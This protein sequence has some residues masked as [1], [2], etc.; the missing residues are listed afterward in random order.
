M[1]HV[2]MQCG[3]FVPRP[4]GPGADV[5]SVAAKESIRSSATSA[6]GSTTIAKD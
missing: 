3:P 2:R 4:A 1:D 5:F 6:A